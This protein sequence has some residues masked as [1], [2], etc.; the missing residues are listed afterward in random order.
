MARIATRR[1]LKKI[2]TC[3]GCETFTVDNEIVFHWKGRKFIADVRNDKVDVSIWYDWAELEV[4]DPEIAWK[5]MHVVNQAND[6][7]PVQAI[8]SYD[9]EENKFCISNKVCFC[10]QPEI[11]RK[12]LYVRVMLE[13][14]L[15]A[16]KYIENLYKTLMHQKLFPATLPLPHG[17]KR[18][19]EVHNNNEPP[20]GSTAN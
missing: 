3:M 19:Y 4:F 15:A 18:I 12:V 7:F 10:L 6:I 8:Y 20:M 5:L 17:V 2:L 9:G 13:R 11:K 14:L 1:L 16:R